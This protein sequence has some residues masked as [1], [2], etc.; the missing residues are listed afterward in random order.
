MT[1][2]ASPKP[3]YPATSY[4]NYWVPGPAR[5]VGASL[6]T[7]DNVARQM[8]ITAIRKMPRGSYL[9]LLTEAELERLAA[10]GYPRHEKCVPFIKNN[11]PHIIVPPLR[12]G[13]LWVPVS[14][15]KRAAEPEA[16]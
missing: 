10:D 1:G 15:F 9:A 8:E 3:T 2:R 12:A 6:I 14:Q 16:S 5:T 7:H 11:N 13:D 4:V